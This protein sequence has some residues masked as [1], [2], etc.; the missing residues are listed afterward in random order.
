MAGIFLVFVLGGILRDFCSNFGVILWFVGSFEG[1]LVG[2]SDVFVIYLLVF[3]FYNRNRYIWLYEFR[4]IT[5]KFF[6]FRRLIF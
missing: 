6:F 5:L 4:R 1:N 2:T 3:C